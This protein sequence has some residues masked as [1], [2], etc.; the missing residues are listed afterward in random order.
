[1][2]HRDQ[3]LEIKSE[4]GSLVSELHNLQTKS[5]K[6]S[7][8]QVDDHY[9]VVK[10]REILDELTDNN[11]ILKLDFDTSLKKIESKLDQ[12][13]FEEEMEQLRAMMM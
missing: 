5:K 12:E 8:N 13:A 11:E 9:Q 2:V 10:F 1:M 3:Y 6:N 7:Q 4:L